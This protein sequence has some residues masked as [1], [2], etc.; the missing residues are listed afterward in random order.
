MH[1]CTVSYRHLLLN[2]SKNLIKKYSKFIKIENHF[3]CIVSIFSEQT[4]LPCPFKSAFGFRMARKRYQTPHLLRSHSHQSQGGPQSQQTS[5]AAVIGRYDPAPSESP[6]MTFTIVLS[7]SGTTRLLT[8]YLTPAVRAKLVNYRP[9]YNRFF[10]LL[11]KTNNTFKT[12]EKVG[13]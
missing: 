11:F 9:Q 13:R 8:A 1:Q 10:P 4:L 5:N 12:G 3:F 2:N 6:Q 7:P